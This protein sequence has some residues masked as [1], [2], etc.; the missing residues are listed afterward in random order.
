[1]ACDGDHAHSCGGNWIL[2]VYFLSTSTANPPP[3]TTGLPGNWVY[4]GCLPW[5]FDALR[6]MVSMFTT[7][8]FSEPGNNGRVFPYMISNPG[9]NTPIACMNQCAAFGFSAAGLE[10]RFQIVPSVHRS[11]NFF[12]LQPYITNSG[13]KNAVS[14]HPHWLFCHKLKVNSGCGDTTDVHSGFVPDSQCNVACDGDHNHS[15]GGSWILNVYYWPGITTW[16]TPGNA[17]QYKASISINF[18]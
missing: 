9:T 10:V 4:K 13:D 11:L 8:F 12:T 18:R 5:A 7:W 1:M 6:W 17:G 2:N 3:L 15:C 14:R 16:H